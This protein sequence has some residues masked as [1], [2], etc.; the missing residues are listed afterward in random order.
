MELLISLL[1]IFT[2]NAWPEDSVL[3]HDFFKTY[4]KCDKIKEM[5]YL[6]KDKKKK[7]ES[8][9]NIKN[10]PGVIKSYK[11]KCSDQADR[12]V[13]LVSDMIRTHYQKA[14]IEIQNDKVKKI[15]V[16][17]FSEPKKYMAPLGYIEKFLNKSKFS[18]VDGLTGAT[19]T[20]SSL[21]RLSK[22]S[23]ELDRIK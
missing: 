15:E 6:S 8:S 2:L 7:I 17:H 20:R 11:I 21:I 22:L 16:V 1:F 10:L 12:T 9:A 5:V 23:L 14:F 13:F 18:D 3:G 19:L 4:A